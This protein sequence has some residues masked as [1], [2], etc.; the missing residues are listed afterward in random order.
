MI[1][2][3]R[4]IIR[5]NVSSNRFAESTAS[6]RVIIPGGKPN[7]ANKSNEITPSRV[8]IMKTTKTNRMI[9]AMM[10]NRSKMIAKSD[11]IKK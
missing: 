1:G 9:A 7:Q 11:N 6:E 4:T 5:I 2:G 8:I 10:A 3:S